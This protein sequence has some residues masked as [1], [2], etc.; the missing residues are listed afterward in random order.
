MQI[1]CPGQFGDGDGDG[2][3]QLKENILLKGSPGHGSMFVQDSAGAKARIV[4]DRF[5]NELS[6]D[7]L[8]HVA[9]FLVSVT[10]RRQD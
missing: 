5:E 3:K 10:M 7:V 8:L 4:I 9:G 1:T 6:S 2:G